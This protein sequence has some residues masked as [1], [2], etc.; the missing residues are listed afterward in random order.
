MS[1][2]SILQM[3]FINAIDTILNLSK[4]RYKEFLK[5]KKHEL[6]KQNRTK[7]KKYG[8]RLRYPGNLK[9]RK[10]MRAYFSQMMD[11]LEF[12]RAERKEENK[13]YRILRAMYIYKDIAHKNIVL[14]KRDRDDLLTEIENQKTERKKDKIS[15]LLIYRIIDMIK[16]EVYHERK[17]IYDES[18]K[19]KYIVEGIKS[20]LENEKNISYLKKSEQLM[21]DI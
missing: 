14:L 13:I 11:F 17:D 3:D 4:I 1:Q 6:L 8:N 7:G 12:P 9:Q 2:G 10:E 18:L 21:K 16:E 20:I 15:N 19:N 5:V